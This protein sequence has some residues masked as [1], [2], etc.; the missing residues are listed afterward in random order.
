LDM[1]TPEQRSKNMAAIKKPQYKA[2]N[3]TSQSSA[4]DGNLVPCGQHYRR[5]FMPS[6][7]I[8]EF[9]VSNQ[10][11]Q[12]QYQ[13]VKNQNLSFNFAEL[14]LIFKIALDEKTLFPNIPLLGTPNEKDY[15]QKWVKSYVDAQNTLP[16]NRNASPKGSC[17]D[18]AI[19]AIVQASTGIGDELA[20]NG[21][22]FHNL[23]MSAENIQGNLLEEYIANNIK[24]YDWVWC[25]GNVMRSVD[26]CSI[27]GKM[28]LQI[29][30]KSNTENSSSSAIRTGT[31]IKKWY[32][33]GTRTISGVKQPRYMWDGLNDIIN[34]YNTNT[35]NCQ[36]NEA[37]YIDFLKSISLKN[38]NLITDK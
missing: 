4:C 37:G 38:R 12:K 29:K 30:N 1:K 15:L 16:S 28:L 27:N 24:Q 9:K 14:D 5:F 19:K 13:S 10:Q 26:F 2:G 34:S 23:F 33:L 6:Y 32:R 8:T 35:S 7:S 25:N 17:S 36:L 21:E 31:S 22:R 18:P 11:L 20:I 3:E